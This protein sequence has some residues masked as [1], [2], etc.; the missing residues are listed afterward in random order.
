MPLSPGLLQRMQAIK[1]NPQ[2]GHHSPQRSQLAGW[3]PGPLQPMASGQHRPMHVSAPLLYQLLLR[4]A[5]GMRGAQGS[6]M[7]ASMRNAHMCLS[8]G[9][10]S[11]VVLVLRVPPVL[12]GPHI[13]SL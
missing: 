3:G 13:R 6:G 11:L 10:L 12:V 7:C 5:E 2:L 8:R 1:E 9:I 4:T